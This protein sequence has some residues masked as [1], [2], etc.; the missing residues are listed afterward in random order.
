MLMAETA[1]LTLA[2]QQEAGSIPS[3]PTVEDQIEQLQ[4]TIDLLY[5][6]E[7]QAEDKDAWLGIV[8]TLEDMLKDLEDAK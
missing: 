3:E 5:A 1:P 8:T 4:Q 2:A 7:G 6:V